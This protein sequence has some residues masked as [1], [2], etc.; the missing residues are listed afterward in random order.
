[1]TRR[2]KGA[3][4]IAIRARLAGCPETFDNREHQ[5]MSVTAH[6]V[7]NTGEFQLRQ[8]PAPQAVGVD[9]EITVGLFDAMVVGPAMGIVGLK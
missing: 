1:L 4:D 2:G 9:P 8:P 6:V 3:F 7:R 5:L